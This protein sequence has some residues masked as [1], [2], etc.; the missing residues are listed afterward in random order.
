MEQEKRVESRTYVD[1]AVTVSLLPLS[2]VLT[3]FTNHFTGRYLQLEAPTLAWIA[4]A[5]IPSCAVIFGLYA[6]L[7]DKRLLSWPALQPEDRNRVFRLSAIWLAL[8][9]AGSIIVAVITGDWVV[10]AR[11]FPAIAAFLVF[12]PLGEELLFRGLI[13]QRVQDLA[14]RSA[15]WPILISS[16]AFSFHHLWLS[17]APDGLALIQVF[18]TIPMGIVFALLRH[19]TKSIWPGFLLHVATNIPATL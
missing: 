13:Y 6:L 1:G 9:L 2:L 8:W 16:L 17:T 18:F 5:A 10:Y 12:G 7:G 14:V 4:T 11:G 15:L 19:Q 3:T